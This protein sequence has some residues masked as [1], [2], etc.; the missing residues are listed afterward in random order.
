MYKDVNSTIEE[1]LMNDLTKFGER[2]K[3]LPLTLASVLLH[4]T[5]AR[6]RAEG[7]TFFCKSRLRPLGIP[8]AQPKLDIVRVSPGNESG[9]PRNLRN[10]SLAAPVLGYRCAPR[11]FFTI[12]ARA[13]RFGRGIKSI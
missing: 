11:Y 13:W 8:F 9:V 5:R 3:Q 2:L 12:G 10:A 6:K 1:D 7:F 4:V